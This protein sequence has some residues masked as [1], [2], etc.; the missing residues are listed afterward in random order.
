M[1]PVLTMPIGVQKTITGSGAANQ[2]T[3]TV[4]AGKK[5]IVDL[6]GFICA[7]TATVGSRNA[8]MIVVDELGNAINLFGFASTASQTQRG[9]AFCGS[10]FPT[11]VTYNGNVNGGLPPVLILRAGAYIRWYDASSIDAAD[12]YTLFVRVRELPDA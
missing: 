4:P 5:W 2:K 8:T 11:G 6:L 12:A 9:S 7:N 1:E 10:N 3:A